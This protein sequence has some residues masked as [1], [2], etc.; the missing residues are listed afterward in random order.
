[1]LFCPRHSTSGRALSFEEAQRSNEEEKEKAGW[2]IWRWGAGAGGTINHPWIRWSLYLALMGSEGAFGKKYGERM[3]DPG[4]WRALRTESGVDAKRKDM[5]SHLIPWCLYWKWE[6]N[7]PKTCRR[8][9]QFVV[10][11]VLHYTPYTL[12]TVTP[13]QM[14]LRV[15]AC[16]SIHGFSICGISYPWIPVCPFKTKGKMLELLCFFLLYCIK[17]AAFPGL[18][19]AFWAPCSLF[20]VSGGSSI[21]QK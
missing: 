3:K 5:Q 11:I 1:M 2:P 8:V 7:L 16:P 6:C 15:Q 9:V 19:A 21:S 18:Q 13:C 17:T 10:R 20:W 4:Q 12:K 14:V